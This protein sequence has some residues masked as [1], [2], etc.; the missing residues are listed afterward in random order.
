MF[1][2]PFLRLRVRYARGTLRQLA[3]AVT[4]ICALVGLAAGPIPGQT[5]DIQ[6]EVPADLQYTLLTRIL[7]FDRSM[8]SFPG[9]ELN[10]ALVHQPGYPDSRDFAREFEAAWRST[11]MREFQG[12]PILFTKIELE[13]VAG[14]ERDLAAR[15]ADIV[16]IAPLRAVSAAAVIKAARRSGARTVAAVPGYVEA[17]AAVGFAV[18]GGKARIRINLTSARAEGSDFE[19]KL[20]HLADVLR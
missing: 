7:T 14:L 2:V 20:L 6:V 11:T 16:I 10:I 17:G 4:C 19:A 8:G 18:Q 5:V 3:R 9:K 13:D 15:K 12:K 1:G